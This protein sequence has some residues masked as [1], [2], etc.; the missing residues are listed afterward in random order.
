M[1][2]W[3]D[4]KREIFIFISWPYVDG[5]CRRRN[6]NEEDRRKKIR[7]EKERALLKQFVAAQREVYW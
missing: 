7:F 4:R 1:E 2:I 3:V 5:T 6:D